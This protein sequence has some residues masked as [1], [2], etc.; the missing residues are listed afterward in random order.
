MAEIIIGMA[1]P[2]TP[3]LAMAPEL[4]EERAAADR[5]NTNLVDIDGRVCTYEQLAQRTGNRYA[6]YATTTNF[7]QQ[8]AAAQAALDR[9]AA[10]LSAAKPDLVVL[11]SH[12]NRDLFTPE[13]QPVMC[14]YYGD[15]L[16]TQKAKLAADA[17][18]WQRQL[19]KAQ[20]QDE[21]HEFPVAAEFARELIIKLMAHQCDTASADEIP[22]PD[23]QAFGYTFSFPLVRLVGAVPV[24]PVILNALLAPNQPSPRRCYEL[25]RIL[26]AAIADTA[27]GARVALLTSVGMCHFVVNEELDKQVLGAIK[28]G[29][30]QTLR[31]IPTKL[32]AGNNGQI[33]DLIMT[34]GAMEGRALGWS[35][36]IPVYRTAA[37]TG[38]G[39]AALRWQ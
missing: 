23:Q 34:A 11:L 24:V 21:H 32:L 27:P 14:V 7:K 25:G 26:R 19:A 29:D 4:W 3:M 17:P 33:R 38:V 6:T 13:N 22:Q 12:D 28:N 31:T 39:I 37:G 18:S 10:E 20:G 9:L 5:R 35:E 36:Y 8:N 2:N 15:K 1:S 16:I 30:S